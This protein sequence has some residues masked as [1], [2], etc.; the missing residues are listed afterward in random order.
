[1]KF[2]RF[3]CTKVSTEYLPVLNAISNG[4][5]Y[6]NPD[7]FNIDETLMKRVEKSE[8]GNGKIEFILKIILI[9]QPQK[10]GLTNELINVFETN[11]ICYAVQ[12]KQL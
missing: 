2:F 4:I 7:G 5:T 8:N 11:I 3:K 10:G 9:S 1:M 12:K 6:I